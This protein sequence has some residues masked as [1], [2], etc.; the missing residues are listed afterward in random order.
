MTPS[1]LSAIRV[2]CA[3]ATGWKKCTPERFT[4][5]ERLMYGADWWYDVEKTVS[6]FA[7]L[8]NYPE[9]ANSA[10]TL[11]DALAD[12]GYLYRAFSNI[13]G[14]IRVEFFLQED[15]RWDI[16]ATAP[17]FALALCQA[18]L[19]VHRSKKA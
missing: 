15:S 1:E 14:G 18:F 17:T 6:C 12:E 10:L 2:E 7:N 4:L 3:E 9:D 8:P 5:M 13:G 19:A 11:A 16:H